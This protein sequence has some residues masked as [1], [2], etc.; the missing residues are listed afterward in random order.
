LDASKLQ[1]MSRLYRPWRAAAHGCWIAAG[2]LLRGSAG[3][4]TIFAWIAWFNHRRLLEPMGHVPPAEFEAAL[5]REEDPS[6]PVG[7]VGSDRQATC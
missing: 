4:A 5:G 2:R 1:M 6:Y 7:S 3:R